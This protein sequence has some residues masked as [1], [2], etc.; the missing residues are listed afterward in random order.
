MQTRIPLRI[1]GLPHWLAMSCLVATLTMSASARSE[2]IP[3]HLASS[4]S[5]ISLKDKTL[6]NGIL[7]LVFDREIVTLNL[8]V[9][10]SSAICAPLYLHGKQGWGSAKIKSAIVLNR[11]EGQG[12]SLPD[13]A[14]ECKAMGG[15][16]GGDAV[17]K[18]YLRNRLF[19]CQAGLQCR[20]RRS[21]DVIHE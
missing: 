19:V 9:G 16:S 7:R 15:L 2:P 11:S 20:P 10:A 14:A 12:Y 3:T 13:V 4:L 18:D 1:N 21:Q 5:G 17:I 8:M 6:D